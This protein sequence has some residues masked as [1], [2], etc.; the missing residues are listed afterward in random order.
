MYG[1]Y[2]LKSSLESN[3]LSKK[4]DKSNDGFWRMRNCQNV[5]NWKWQLI[6]KLTL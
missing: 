1:Y 4:A 6:W 3:V 2:I 5:K